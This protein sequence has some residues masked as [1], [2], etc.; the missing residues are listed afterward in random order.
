[1]ECTYVSCV[2]WVNIKDGEELRET[3]HK[4]HRGRGRKRKNKEA[5]FLRIIN[6]I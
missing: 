2:L 3:N 1:V 6:I 4:G 5:V